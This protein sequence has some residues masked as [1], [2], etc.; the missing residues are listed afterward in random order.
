MLGPPKGWFDLVGS[1]GKNGTLSLPPRGRGCFD[2]FFY[3]SWAYLYFLILIYSAY[4]C[5]F[6]CS[7]RSCYF[8]LFS[9]WILRYYYSLFL[10]YS[11][12]RSSSCL[13][14][15]YLLAYSYLLSCYSLLFCYCCLF[16]YSLLIYSYLLSYYSLLLSS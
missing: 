1:L 13:L 11:A 9:S 6:S 14:C 16:C 10:L 4:L 12:K 15:S 8:L 3:S 7:Y 5:L 2:I